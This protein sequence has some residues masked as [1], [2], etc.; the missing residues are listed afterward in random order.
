V[1]NL[2]I[3]YFN[4]NIIELYPKEVI[5]EDDECLNCFCHIDK[6]EV[7]CSEDCELEYD[8]DDI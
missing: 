2:I 6:C 7:F 3:W 5:I 8:E 4:M 1:V